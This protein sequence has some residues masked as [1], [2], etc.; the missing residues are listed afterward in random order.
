M[1]G[2][3]VQLLSV[4]RAFQWHHLWP[5]RPVTA[6]FTSDEETGS[7]TSR[8]LIEDVARQAAVVFCL[9]P[10]L[11]NGAVKTARKGTGLIDLQVKGV[12]AHAGV[13]HALG[14]NAIE[15]LAHHI[16][17]AQR[18][19]DYERGTTV[20]VGVVHGG[21]RPNVVP[22]EAQAEVDFR[23]ETMDEYTRL[24][25]WV[26]NLAPVLQDTQVLASIHLNR[27]PMPRDETMARTF[28]KACQ[29]G[30]SLGLEL[31]EGSTGGGSD[32][33]FVASL[34]IPVL[35]GLARWRW[36]PFRT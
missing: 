33:N 18:Q 1:K 29:I 12:A 25:V 32:A 5:D 20:N 22:D 14:R 17:A 21:T 9:E 28:E 24:D 34:G 19:T 35:D 30:R 8:S 27:P 7:L 4:I 13:N 23:V 2:G 10:A 16:L 11:A 36:C 26:K 6:L 31:A 15:E 3:I